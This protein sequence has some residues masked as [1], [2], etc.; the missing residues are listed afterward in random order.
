MMNSFAAAALQAPEYGRRDIALLRFFMRAARRSESARLIVLIETWTAFLPRL[1]MT[2]ACAE[3]PRCQ[4][5]RH[6]PAL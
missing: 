4:L 5:H 2:P 6:P 1:A 3:K